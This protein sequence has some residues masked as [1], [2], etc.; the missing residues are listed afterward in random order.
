MILPPYALAFLRFRTAYI[1]KRIFFLPG[2]DNQEETEV[3]IPTWLT[4]NII[5]SSHQTLQCHCVWGTKKIS[6]LL[7][8]STALFECLFFK[9]ETFVTSNIGYEQRWSS[10]SLFSLT[11]FFFLL[12]L[13]TIEISSQRLKFRN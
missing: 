7:Y 1:E 4:V 9:K 3:N 2:I 10:E 13:V 11:K 6:M 12:F 5:L 8:L